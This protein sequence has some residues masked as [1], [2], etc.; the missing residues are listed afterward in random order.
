MMHLRGM[1]RVSLLLHSSLLD[2][3]AMAT[4]LRE[5]FS[6]DSRGRLVTNSLAALSTHRTG[7]GLLAM[8]AVSLSLLFVQPQET[9][10]RQVELF[11]YFS[12]AFCQSF[13]CIDSGLFKPVLCFGNTFGDP[14]LPL[15]LEI[16]GD[17]ETKATEAY[18]I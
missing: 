13:A 16:E 11:L 6:N 17:V 7:K 2:F 8:G 3:G 9:R 5:T 4:R 10:H 18:F 15:L 14:L 12:E 1:G